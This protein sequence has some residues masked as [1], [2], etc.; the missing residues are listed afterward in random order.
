[1]G[2]LWFLANVIRLLVSTA[3]T[4]R[5]AAFMKLA[6]GL[7]HF[8]VQYVAGDLS[9]YHR[10]CTQAVIPFLNT[11]AQNRNYRVSFEISGSGL[12]F[13]SQHY[14]FAISLLRELIARSQVELVSSTY[15]PT[16]WVAFPKL[17]LVRSIQ[18]N[19]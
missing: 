4:S 13:L 11:I 1:M 3:W 8:N 16:L 10:Y 14:P 5:R 9:S 18:L 2:W 15:A 19:Q 17:D 6:L 7:F 12:E